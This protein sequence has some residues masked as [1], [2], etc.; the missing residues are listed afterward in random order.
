VKKLTALAMVALACSALAA[1]FGL[2]D[3][4]ATRD[5]VIAAAGEPVKELELGG[6]HFLVYADIFGAYPAQL[7][8]WLDAD[9]GVLVAGVIS[10]AEATLATFYAWEREL[11]ARFGEATVDDEFATNDEEVRARASSGYAAARE[12][13]VRNGLYRLRRAWDTDTT[14]ASL[15]AKGGA[16]E[17]SVD[18]ILSSTKLGAPLFEVE[19]EAA[20][21]EEEAPPP[22]ETP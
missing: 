10:P 20:P 9:D 18:A 19:E 4:G 21:A 17:L 12:E 1:D 14:L 16:G 22:E 5:E 11:S 13:D 2:A 6:N 7:W 15:V 8:Y 3:W